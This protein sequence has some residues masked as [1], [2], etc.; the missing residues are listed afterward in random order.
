[1]AD[2]NTFKNCSNFTDDKPTVVTLV[3]GVS[4]AVCCVVLSVVLVALV[5]LKLLPKSIKRLGGTLIKR[6]TFGTE[7]GLPTQFCTASCA[8]LL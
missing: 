8:L 7:C 1:M 4:A 6:L 5:A 2:L 3:R